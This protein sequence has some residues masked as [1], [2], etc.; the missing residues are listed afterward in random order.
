[1]RSRAL[2]AYINPMARRVVMKKFESKHARAVD[3]SFV[4]EEVKRFSLDSTGD[5]GC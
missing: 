3:S 1:V 5:S 4:N 2:F